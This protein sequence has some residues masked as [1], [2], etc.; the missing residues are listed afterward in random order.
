MMMGLR[1]AKSLRAPLWLIA[2]GGS[3]ASGLSEMSAEGVEISVVTGW[4]ARL[5][6]WMCMPRG[7]TAPAIYETLFG[8]LRERLGGMLVRQDQAAADHVS[9]SYKRLWLDGAPRLS[10]PD[11]RSRDSQD[12]LA[13]ELGVAPQAPLVALEVGG[14]SAARQG[15]AGDLRAAWPPI[16]A[17]TATLESYRPAISWLQSQGFTVVRV[18]EAGEPPLGWPGVVDVAA[19]DLPETVQLYCIACASFVIA[20]APERAAWAWALGRPVLVLNAVDPISAFPVREADLFTLRHVRPRGEDRMLTLRELFSDGQ[21]GSLSAGT[22]ACDYVDNTP[23]EV[24]AAVQDMARSAGGGVAP[25]APEQREFRLLATRAGM[26]RNADP[27]SADGRGPHHS[28][29]GRGRLAPSFA[30]AFLA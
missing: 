5:M 8:F 9:P 15:A 3:A 29:L 4:R 1:L 27:R 6:E 13:E 30:R 7:R 16:P 22:G 11:R 12:R 23:D 19:A 18:G 17:G 20:D 10:L 28:Y 14:S 26:Q 24:L 21:A 2:P 25:E